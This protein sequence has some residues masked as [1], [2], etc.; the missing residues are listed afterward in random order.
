MELS[1]HVKQLLRSVGIRV[2]NI[3]PF[4]DYWELVY[5]AP[6]VLPIKHRKPEEYAEEKKMFIT[7]HI[8]KEHDDKK[9]L[10]T[11]AS[12]LDKYIDALKEAQEEVENIA[13]FL[14][15]EDVR[16]NS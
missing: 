11:L 2:I 9:M 5:E 16:N 13:S 8:F 10:W 15:K 14:E 7:R 4:K 1:Y 6:F 3:G 12:D